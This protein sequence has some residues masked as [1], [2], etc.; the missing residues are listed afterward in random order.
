MLKTLLDTLVF[1]VLVICFGC[2][3][4]AGDSTEETSDED[5]SVGLKTL[6]EERGIRFGAF[7]Q[8][9]FRGDD[10]DEIFETEFN[11]M[12]AG[13][14][15]GDGS[16][17][18]RTEFDFTEMDDKVNFGRER[19]MEVHGHTLVWFDEIPDWLKETSTADIEAIMNER[20]DALVGRYKGMIKLWDVVNEPVN[21]ETGTLRLDHK[22]AEAMGSDYIAKAFA[23][24]HDADPDAVLRLNEYGIQD[25]TSKYEGFKDLLINLKNE[26]VPVHAVGWQM[27]V[28]PGSFDPDTFL[29]RLNEI[30]DLGFDNYITE[31]DVELPEDATE[32]DLEEQKQT[33]K[34]VVETFLA[35]RRIK[36]VVTWGLSDGDPDW[37][38]DN[39][40]FLFD[41]DLNK[42]PA[43]DGVQEALE[44]GS[45]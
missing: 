38:T 36:S 25:D 37:L 35:A 17:N 12:T 27:H 19:D 39:H 44:G 7:Y 28:K 42:K 16:Q 15:I 3:S 32:T 23:R 6:A 8:Y 43:Y 4:A 10:Y 11:T 41:E 18:S 14:F 1:C 2:G 9:V 45:E 20:I 13:T 21:D 31:L 40:P 33:Y 5:S 34:E 24:A 29:D 22:W 26:G 30:A